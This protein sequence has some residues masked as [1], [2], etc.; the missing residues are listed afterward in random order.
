MPL[1]RSLFSGFFALVWCA[2]LTFSSSAS[3][4]D[5]STVQ[6]AFQVAR[7]AVKPDLQTK[8]ISLYGIG[9]P[10]LIQKWY[11][12]FYDPTV[13]SHGRSVF[14][15][16]GQVVK[17]YE[18]RGGVIYSSHLTFDPSRITEEQP[19]LNAAQNYA[20]HHHIA[21]NSVRALLKQTS[22]TRPFRWRIELLDSGESRGFVLINAVDDTVA[23]F[24]PPAVH[25][26]SSSASA[27]TTKS[28]SASDSVESDATRFGDDVKNTFLGI[29]GDLQQFFTGER[30]V[31]K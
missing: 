3:A 12:I 30:T 20:T 11:I 23:S 15:Q 27:A 31:D 8:V 7:G 19:A 2:A 5:T 22:A 24:V 13:P 4:Q 6:Q 25:H 26:G 28:A 29:G 16:N 10:D 14:V 18:A 9:T 21:Y 17:T 1:K